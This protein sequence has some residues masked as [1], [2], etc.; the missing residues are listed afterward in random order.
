MR[1]V[2]KRAPIASSF[3][4]P[5]PFSACVMDAMWLFRNEAT[6]FAF[7]SHTLR[8]PSLVD[9]HFLRILGLGL[10]Q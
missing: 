9:K 8:Q 4:N 3:P 5:A 7:E 2:L 1:H 6:S 10:S